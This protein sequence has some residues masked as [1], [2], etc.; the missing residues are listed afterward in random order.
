MQYINKILNT[1]FK[2][3]SKMWREEIVVYFFLFFAVLIIFS[4]FNYSVIKHWEY[5]EVAKRQ[6]T[7]ETTIEA[8]RWTILSSNDSWNIFAISVDLHNL[9]IDPSAKWNKKALSDFLTQVIYQEICQLKSPS[10][11]YS[12]L[13]KFLRVLSIENFFYDKKYIKT[14]VKERIDSQ[15]SRTKVTSVLLN[16]NL[17]EEEIFE[18]EKKNL[19]SA[20]IFRNWL[21][22]NPEEI[23]N[24]DLTIS[25]IKDYT[26]YW[27]SDLKALLRKRD[28]KYV[29]IFN[30]L[31]V[32]TWEYIR[33]FL[34]T[35]KSAK[36]EGLMSY[37]DGISNFIILN[38]IQS[39]VYPEETI[40]SQILWFVSS[41]NV[42]RYWIEWY[43]NELL[44][45]K[46]AKLN[47]TKTISS[48]WFAINP[49]DINFDESE[50]WWAQI[51][52]TVDKNI[53]SRVEQILK[54]RVEEFNANKWSV[55]I[56]EPK[57]GRVLSMVNYPSYN[58]NSFWDVYEIE[59]VDDLKYPWETDL[60]WKS[61]LVEDKIE[62]EKFFYQWKEILLRKAKV[63]E[64]ENSLMTK[65]IYKNG[66]WPAV[67]KNDSV[68][69]LYEPGSI[70]K[71]ITVAIG[72]ETW[73]IDRFWMF[74]DRWV[75]KIEGSQP[76]WN[77]LDN[78]KCTW[79]LNYQTAL[80]QSCNTWMT[81]IVDKIWKSL[82][83][84]YL[85]SFG[86]LEKTWI[87][88]DWEVS[89]KME[90]YE[91]WPRIKLFTMSFGQWISATPLQLAA[92]YAPLANWWV[93]MQPY[94]VDKISFWDWRILKNKPIAK[95]QVI[96]E[97]TSKEITW[98]LV[99]WVENWAAKRAKIEGYD[100]AWKTWTWEI[101]NFWI[102]EDTVE[103]R[104]NASFAWYAPAYDPK[105][106]IVVKLERPRTSQYWGRTS[107]LIF[108]DIASYLFDYY[109]IPKTK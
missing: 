27:E 47:F 5:K 81:K 17:T 2:K 90:P 100:I 96:S 14:L 93:Y 51:Q 21:Y 86:F 91:K 15:I 82:F 49:T 87:S 6:Q 105:F 88:L 89:Q 26:D 20:Y 99:D 4:L 56:M 44:R 61:V 58:P 8:D 62:W 39:R 30:R 70:F 84:S 109:W 108:K 9:A 36:K 11:C 29:R 50:V 57:T 73:E 60:L 46:D 48:A 107:A 24:I 78:P 104:T 101:A 41:D 71:P 94:I 97:K 33:E 77:A 28:L 35:E 25:Q 54:N 55:V 53:Q 92:S 16:S 19:K 67:Y 18:L 3:I 98:M 45:W 106:V 68:E 65:Y 69:S 76:I 23:G 79:Y 43:F 75:V 64:I 37:D 38:P 74:Y 59:K 12:W 80:S 103:G 7:A 1:L 52:L 10:S 102:Y 22:L 40:W 32:S 66:F 13:I 95:R 83:Y 85:E 42:W 72:L 63:D 31:S 34:K